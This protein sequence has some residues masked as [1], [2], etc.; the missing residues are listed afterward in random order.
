VP[1]R[2]HLDENIPAT[3][4][5]GL[6][7]RD[8]DVTTAAQA[9]LIAATDREHLAFAAG[10]ARVLVTQDSDFLRL[11]AEGVPHA[12]IAYCRQHA[13]SIGEMLRRLAL[14]HDLL[15][16]EEMTGRIEFL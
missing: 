6:R 12:G 10:E 4:A 11:H 9:N 16:A 8:I 7:R 3:V 15:T 5:T 1:I 13:L 2:F 14:L